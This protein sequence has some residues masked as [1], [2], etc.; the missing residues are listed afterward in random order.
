MDNALQRII[1]QMDSYNNQI[2][3]LDQFSITFFFTCLGFVGVIIGIIATL[4]YQMGKKD[5]YHNQKLYK[6][7]TVLTSCIPPIFA[8]Y[9]MV[10]VLNCRKVATYRGYL[11]YLETKYNL[12]EKLAPQKYNTEAI[13]SIDKFSPNNTQ[14]SLSNTVVL[15]IILIGILVFITL[16]FWASFHLIKRV[17]V[18]NYTGDNRT[19]IYLLY[20]LN[21]VLIY[22]CSV[23]LFTTINDLLI[24][25][26]EPQ[27]LANKLLF[28]TSNK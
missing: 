15:I 19:H 21:I 1:S 17:K 22:L 28:L 7:N 23:V 12:D 3:S 24:N 14:G 25:P 18:I 26:I 10:A 16:C 8:S 27:E 13:K 4:F 11:I 2:E 5:D 9:A 6:I 20:L